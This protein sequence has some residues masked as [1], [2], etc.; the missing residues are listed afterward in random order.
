MPS[1]DSL[2]TADVVEKVFYNFG[3]PQRIISDNAKTFKS[4]NFL[5]MLQKHGVKLETNAV[6]HPQNNP[7]ERVNRVI[8]DSLRA[9]ISKDHRTWENFIKP[10]QAAINS[11]K[12]DSTKNSPY[13]VVFKSEMVTNGSDHYHRDVNK[14]LNVENNL[15]NKTE[16]ETL[17][18]EVQNNITKAYNRYSHNYNLRSKIQNYKVGDLVYKK[19]HH[20]SDKA[21]NFSAKLA[22]KKTRVRITKIMGSNTYQVEDASGKNLGVYSG[23]QLYK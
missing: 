23:S 22:P 3:V 20:L 10:I 21:K 6:Y 7:S 2:K 12:H 15:C 11:A 19:N 5:E 18:Q 1:M 17:F 4:S 14:E 9:C 8:T 13:F 16:I